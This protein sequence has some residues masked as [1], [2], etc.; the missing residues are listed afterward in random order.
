MATVTIAP[1]D[2]RHPPLPAGPPQRPLGRVALAVLSG[3]VLLLGWLLLVAGG[4]TLA[5]NAMMRDSNGYLMGEPTSWTSP[6]YAVQTE[7]VLVH[8]GPLGFTMPHRMLGR[9]H[10]HAVPTGENGVFVGV[11]RARDVARYLDDVAR[12]TIRDPYADPSS[13]RFVDGGSP[14][15][16]PTDAR[17][18]VA[19]AVGTGPQSITWDPRPGT[20]R[21][22]V[23]N[24]EGT[25]PVSA[26]VSVGAEVPALRSAGR[27]LV[28]AGLLVLAVGATGA[29]LSTRRR[30]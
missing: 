8:G 14:R 21:L 5:A 26:D 12:T 23:M 20:W 6:G 19:S 27:T 15:V 13:A 30:S 1:P 24:A 18:W 10:A 9:F 4:L 3:L 29:L 7:S 16:A 28:V 17:F 11:A 22:V 2:V 25:T